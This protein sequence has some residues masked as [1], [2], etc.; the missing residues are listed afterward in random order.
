MSWQGDIVIE[1]LER[2]LIGGRSIF[3]NKSIPPRVRDPHRGDFDHLATDL[4]TPASHGR[5]AFVNKSG[6]YGGVRAADDKQLLRQSVAACR[7]EHRQRTALL[8]AQA[9]FRNGCQV[10]GSLSRRSIQFRIAVAPR[11]PHRLQYGTR[12]ERRHRN[13]IRP[14]ID[15][16]R[17][18]VAAVPATHEQATHAQ[19]IRVRRVCPRVASWRFHCLAQEGHTGYVARAGWC[20]LICF[21]TAP[22]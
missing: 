14:C 19:R 9:T 10:S 13:V 22:H 18:L 3:G 7:R 16:N 8:G 21:A 5:K 1:A 4:N 20:S 11:L 17:C 6:D 15:I 2:R 12:A